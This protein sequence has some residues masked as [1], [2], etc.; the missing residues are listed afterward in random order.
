MS[1]RTVRIVFMGTPVFAV[2]SLS[3]LAEGHEVV[4]VVTQPDKPRG[5]GLDT[6]PSPV[7]ELATS[8]G[9]PVLEPA[10]LRDEQ[11]LRQLKDLAPEVIVVVAYGKILPKSVLT[12]PPMGCVNLHASVLPKYRGAA[13]INRAII[14]G[15]METGNCTMLMDEGMDT[16]G[17]LLCEKEPISEEDTAED[18]FKRLSAK[19]AHLLRVTIERLIEGS[20]TPVPQ[21][22]SKATYAPMLRKEDGR[23]DWRKGAL[24]IK[25]HLR[26]LYPWPGAFTTWEKGTLKVHRGR[27]AQAESVSGAAHG[28][29]VGLTREGILVECGSGVFEITELQPENKK[30]MSAVDFIKGYRLKVGERF[31]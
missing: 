8:N 22:S 6:V 30:R 5:R 21:D 27:V 15:E 12:L 14:N 11:F 23:I 2:P 17:V 24:E 28:T 20:I 29:V 9:I 4:A 19:G 1:S 3:A 25:N 18:L 31:A 13:P 7:K 26:G 10:K 16:G